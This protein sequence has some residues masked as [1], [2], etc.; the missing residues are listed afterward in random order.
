MGFSSWAEEGYIRI[1]RNINSRSGKYG[2]A[3]YFTYPTIRSYP[4]TDIGNQFEENY[5]EAEVMTAST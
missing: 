2:I 1:H 5:I 4:L 3:R